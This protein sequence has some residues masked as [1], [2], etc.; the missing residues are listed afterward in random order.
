LDFFSLILLA[1][2]PRFFAILSLDNLPKKNRLAQGEGER[3]GQKGKSTE[4]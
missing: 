1:I 2:T 4:G 3:K